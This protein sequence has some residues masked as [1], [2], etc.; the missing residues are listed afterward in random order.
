M[1]YEQIK[2]HCFL[3]QFMCILLLED[4]LWVWLYSFIYENTNF[5]VHSFAVNSVDGV[6]LLFVARSVFHFLVFF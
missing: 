5:F 6:R 3:N 1:K 4:R 2:T